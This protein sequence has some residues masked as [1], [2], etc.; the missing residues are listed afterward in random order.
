M[1]RQAF[2]V[3]FWKDK[4]LPGKPGGGGGF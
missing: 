2:F 4:A 1:A 3:L